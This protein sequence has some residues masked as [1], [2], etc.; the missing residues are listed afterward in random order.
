[1]SEFAELKD[2]TCI[3]GI[4]ETAYTRGTKKSALELALEASISA[5]EDAGIKPDAID[6]VI[7]PGGAGGGGTAGDFIANL[8]LQDLHYTASLQEMG[9]AMSVSAVECAVTAL[10]TGIA[11]YALIPLCS[12]FYSG[13]RARQMNSDPGTG[14]QSAGTIRDYYAPFGVAAPPQ[15]YAWMA[16]RHM[17]L[18]GTTHEQLGAVAVAMRRHAQMHPNAVMK[19]IPMNL[20][21][22]LA[23][24]WVSYPYRLLDC[25]LETDGAA[26]LLM[27]TADRAKDARSRPIY[28]MGVAS[29]HPYP[30]HDLPNRDDILKMGLDYCAPRAYA[31]AGVQPSDVDFAEIYDCFTGQLILQLEAA[32]FCKRGEGGP[33]V[34]NGRIELGGELPVNTHGGLLSQAHN[35]GMNHVVEAVVQLRHQAGPRQVNDAELGLVT[36]WGGHGHGSIAI[37]HR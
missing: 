11:H 20:E 9:G 12:R 17:H 10:A 14:L 8:G 35:A 37:L 6:A 1:M 4:G 36:G 19:A 34:E 27:T 22:Y 30:P 29:G 25:C 21:D 33:F 26:A 15:H 2:R 24:R 31:M 28:V 16:Q 23:S 3:L 13:R 7:L 5:I 32:G 18:Y